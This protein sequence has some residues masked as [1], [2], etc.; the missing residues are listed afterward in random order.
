VIDETEETPIDLNKQLFNTALCMFMNV[1]KPKDFL[2]FLPLD[3]E[4]NAKILFN[5]LKLQIKK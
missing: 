1:S 3:T 4:V 5:E 2:D